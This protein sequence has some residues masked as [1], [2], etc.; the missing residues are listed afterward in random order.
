VE[1]HRLLPTLMLITLVLLTVL[2]W[3]YPSTGDFRLDN[4]FW[5]GLTTFTTKFEASK[6]E[7][8]NN[9][10]STA[11]GTVLILIPYSQLTGQ[12][13][14]RLRSYVSTGGTLIVLDDYGFGNQVLSHLGLEMR[15]TGS[16]LLDPLFNYK[17]KRLPKIT[18][19]PQTPLTGGIKSM[20]LNHATALCNVS[21]SE[22]LAR[23]SRFS[24]LDSDGD[25]V[26][27]PDEPTG[28]FPVAAYARVGEGYVV[29]VADP[30]IIIN[31]MIV[32]D[33]N[34]AF[35]KN[36][37]GFLG[38][39][40]KVMIDKSHLPTGPLEEAKEAVAKAYALVSSPIGT[41]S[42]ITLILA[43]TLYPLW[44]KR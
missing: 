8:L 40:P 36:I 9:L 3:F 14:E 42:L 21:E 11:K 24:F 5:N 41:L 6:I 25:S 7:S 34:M 29:A 1:P 27:D 10:P 13:L 18:D 26:W 16:P 33:D 32:L 4:P 19:F 31:S 44:K 20:V 15:F 35:M 30:S 39:K 28:P 2:I 22:V 12:E 23:S 17:N 37:V 38:E 43:L